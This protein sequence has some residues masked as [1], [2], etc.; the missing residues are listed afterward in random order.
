MYFIIFEAL[1]RKQANLKET[2]MY[3]IKKAHA[4]KHYLLV[5]K[6][7]HHKLAFWNMAEYHFV[8]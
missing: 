8:K 1:N 3:I 2:V 5:R 7:E 6:K 4:Y